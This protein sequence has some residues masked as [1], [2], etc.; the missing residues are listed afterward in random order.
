MIYQ[1]VSQFGCYVALSSDK[2]TIFTIPMDDDGDLSDESP[3]QVT[4]PDE[5]FLKIVNQMFKT[6]FKMT[7]F[8]GR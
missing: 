2:K 6:S 8:P 4:D 1:A 7:D 3:T 5:D